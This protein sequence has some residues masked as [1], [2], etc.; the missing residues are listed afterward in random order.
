MVKCSIYLNRRDFVMGYPTFKTPRLSVKV[1]AL[2]SSEQHFKIFFLEYNL[3]FTYIVLMVQC[4]ICINRISSL[5]VLKHIGLQCW[6]YVGST[7]AKH[8]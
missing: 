6:W 1:T 4:R 3:D 5:Q 7:F 2:N 8:W